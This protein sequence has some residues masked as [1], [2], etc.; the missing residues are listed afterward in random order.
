MQFDWRWH[1]TKI[2]AAAASAFC[3]VI[4]YVGIA[5]PVVLAADYDDGVRVVEVSGSGS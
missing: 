3:A 2:G 4:I 5:A 1:L